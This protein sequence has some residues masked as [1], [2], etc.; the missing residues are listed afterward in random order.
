MNKIILA[1][2]SIGLV[3]CL[4]GCSAPVALG[5]GQYMHSYTGGVFHSGSAC[6][7]NATE[8]AM[9]FCQD[10]YGVP[11]KITSYKSTEASL[12][13]YPSGT[14]TFKCQKDDS[15]A[16]IELADGTYEL[17]GDATGYEGIKARH[18]LLRKASQF[19][20]KSGKKV[21]PV[22]ATRER[23]T[24]LSTGNAMDTGNSALQNSSASLRFICK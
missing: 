1:L 2:A 10:K 14:V 7:A 13:H 6:V 23:G 15:D 17:V 18:A 11:A 16:P 12:G 8:E 20:A 5:D 9:Q 3:S 4:S 19:C 21:Q 22:E 24:N